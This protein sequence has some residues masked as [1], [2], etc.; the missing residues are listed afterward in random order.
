MTN[1]ITFRM[2]FGIPGDISRPGI[3]TVE[4]Q[5][6]GATPFTAYGVPVKLVGGLVLPITAIGDAIYGI[7]V[8]PFP[9]QGVNA[10]DPLGTS[11]PP[12]VGIANILRRGYLT[13][14]N[15]N[16]AVNAAVAA[17]QVYIWAAATSGNH[18]QGGFEAAASGG[19]TTT[20]LIPATFMSAA[21]SNGNVEI[22][23]NI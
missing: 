4:A 19:N 9:T 17:A 14:L 16:N 7:L 22:A 5:P 20:A 1:A 11:V 23:Y 2:P 21:D 8:R 6:F 12:T 15:N 18:V 3:A 10:S 13:I